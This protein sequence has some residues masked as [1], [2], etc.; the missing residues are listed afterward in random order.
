[1]FKKR[2][3]PVISVPPSAFYAGFSPCETP[4]LLPNDARIGHISFHLCSLLGI[5]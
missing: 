1:V 3:P 5:R 2:E 4:S